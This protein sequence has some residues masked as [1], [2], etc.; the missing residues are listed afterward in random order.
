MGTMLF[1]A[2]GAEA[3]SNLVV[4]G[5]SMGLAQVVVEE[6]LEMVGATIALWGSYEL[7]RDSG[8]EW[9]PRGP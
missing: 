3:L 8:Y 7:A 9:R 1:G 4:E 2:V 5:T 6:L